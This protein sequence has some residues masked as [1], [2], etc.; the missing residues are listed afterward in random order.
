MLDWMAPCILPQ[1][2]SS[3]GDEDSSSEEES[4]MDSEDEREERLA[5]ARAKRQVRHSGCML[6]S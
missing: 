6:R 4:S 5:R 1:Q 3:S 2:E